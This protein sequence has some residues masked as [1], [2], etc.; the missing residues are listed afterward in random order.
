MSIA[1]AQIRFVTDVL[2]GEPDI[3]SPVRMA[4]LTVKD[5]Q[6]DILLQLDPPPGGWTHDRLCQASEDLAG[7]THAGAEGFLGEQWVGSTEV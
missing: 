7:V 4:P 6:G 2:P 1:Q 5:L 3:L